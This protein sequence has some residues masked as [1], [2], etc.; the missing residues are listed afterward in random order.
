MLTSSTEQ[1]FYQNRDSFVESATSIIDNIYKE[2]DKKGYKSNKE[3]LE[4]C[5]ELGLLGVAIKNRFGLNV[6]IAKDRA[7]T[8]NLAAVYTP[9]SVQMVDYTWFDLTHVHNKELRRY[10]EQNS[11]M[12]LT[13]EANK[14]IVSFKLAKIT[15]Y[16]SKF[17]VYVN[18]DIWTLF[19]KIQLTPKEVVAVL[20]HEIG[21]LFVGFSYHY[22]INQLNL[23]T[24]VVVNELI[25]NNEEQAIYVLNNDI[26]NKE[27]LLSIRTNT[28]IRHDIAFA[29]LSRYIDTSM[30]YRYYYSVSNNESMADNFASRF[31]VGKELVGSLEKLDLYFLKEDG[32]AGFSFKREQKIGAQLEQT[33]QATVLDLLGIFP[34]IARVTNTSVIEPILLVFSSNIYTY[35]N[36]YDRYRRIKTSIINNIKTLSHDTKLQKELIEQIDYI[37]SVLKKYKDQRENGI[38]ADLLFTLFI[39]SYKEGQ[40]FKKM[41]NNIEEFLNSD[42]TYLTLKLEKQ[43]V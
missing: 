9:V 14:S 40:R 10:L 20:L 31:N 8:G 7:Y 22:R 24:S 28:K 39:P 21:H 32:I 18:L 27:D 37:D 34:V 23:N 2:I 36:T 26:K 15:G 35:D 5:D 17:A 41:Q 11:S 25:N 38:V 16:Y 42:L 6:S 30:Q 12:L 13:K 33:M 1:I 29:I 3:V 4:N 19:K 43:N